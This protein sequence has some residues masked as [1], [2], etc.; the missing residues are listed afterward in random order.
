MS[1]KTGPETRNCQPPWRVTG[2][3]LAAL[4]GVPPLSETSLYGDDASLDDIGVVAF[5]GDP[6]GARVRAPKP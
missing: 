6:F 5:D 2:S 3:Y 1:T 4:L